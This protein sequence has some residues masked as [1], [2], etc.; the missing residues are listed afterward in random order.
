MFSLIFC[1]DITKI[2]AATGPNRISPKI[3]KLAANIMDSHLTNII[4]N[5]LFKN[6]F[7][8]EAKTATS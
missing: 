8:E 2:Y 4:N 5:D 6:S 3:L 7:S 1:K